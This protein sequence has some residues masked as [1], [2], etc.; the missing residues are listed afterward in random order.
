MSAFGE[1]TA[2]GIAI[3]AAVLSA[4]IVTVIV[5]FPF[6]LLA[7]RAGWDRK[8][9]GSFRRPFRGLLLTIG[10]WIAVAAFWPATAAQLQTVLIHLL[11][12]AAIGAGGWLVAGIVSFLFARTIARHPIDM[13]DN[14]DAR[15]IRTQVI[16][17]RRVATVVIGVV[18]VGAALLTFDGVQ[19]FGA[20]LLASAGIISVVAGIAAQSTLANV[21]AGVQLA[22]SDAIRV[23]DVVIAEGEWGRIEEITLTYIVVKTWDD[24]R[25]VLPSTYFTTT[26]FENWTRSG[27]ALLGSVLLDVDWRISPAGMREHLKTIIE[28]EP[29]WDRRAAVL[30]VVDATGGM[31]RVRILVT[32][33]DAGSLWDLRCK[34]REAM[35]EWV[36]TKSPA[37]LPRQRVQL[38]EPQSRPSRP[39]GA[40]AGQDGLFSGSPDADRRGRDFRGGPGDAPGSLDP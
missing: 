28:D 25:L 19:A 31:V 39:R 24:R 32:A 3:V 9:I 37:A 29:L 27:S 7:R 22:F 13:A 10:L 14:R 34:V 26:P 11:R 15:R 17:L 21:F 16:V 38:V 5:T 1:W 35:V 8:A 20:S 36:H 18:T 6:R 30:Q 2:F 4:V 40:G 23:D 33:A 12:V